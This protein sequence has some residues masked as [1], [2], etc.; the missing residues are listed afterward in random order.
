MSGTARKFPAQVL[1][2]DLDGTLV[3]SLPDL[4][5]ATNRTLAELGL[6]PRAYE[7][8]ATFVGQGIGELV[9]RALGIAP[10]EDPEQVATALATFRRHYAAV[11]GSQATLYPG[12]METLRALQEM[13]RPMAVVTNK[14]EQFTRP[15][16]EQMGI[17]P[18]FAAVVSGDTLPVKKPDP[19]VLTHA[20]AQLGTTPPHEAVMVGDSRNDALAAQA[21]GMPVLLVTY[22]YS[23]GQPIHEIACDA[24]LDRFDQ[25]LHFLA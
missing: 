18:F 21:L 6:P 24:Y 16:L 5:E 14:A 7:E 15:L 25:V 3:D 10:E 2:F 12:V 20:L 22:G 23:E 19:R 11:N 8:I 9:R 1:I 17:A 13:D 4:A